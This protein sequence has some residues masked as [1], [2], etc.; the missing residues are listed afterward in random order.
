MRN[1]HTL[2]VSL[3]PGLLHRLRRAVGGSWCVP[4]PRAVQARAHGPGLTLPSFDRQG[5]SEPDH[6][7]A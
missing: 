2:S 4:V 5:L 1:V 7:A 3:Y 6:P